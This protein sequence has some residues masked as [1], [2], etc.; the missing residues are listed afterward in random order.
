MV[1]EL[2]TINKENIE[3]LIYEIRGKQI[4]LDSDLARIYKCT[5]GT[6]DIN[7]AVNRNLNRFP[8]DFYFQLTKN[9]YEHL[10]FQIG[11]SKINGRGGIRKLPYVF[12]EQGVAMLS[13]ILKTDVAAE[14]SIN[15]MRTF[16]KMRNLIENNIYY[17]KDIGLIENRLIIHDN[18]IEDID[19]S[20]KLLQESFEKL[21]EKEMKEFLFFAGEVFNSYSKIIDIFNMSKNEIIIIDSY[22]DIKLLDIIKDIN[23]KVIIITRKNNLLRELDINKYNKQYSNLEVIYDNSFH[24][25]YI[26]LDKK[27]F[28]SVGTSFNY[29]GN[30]TF[31][32]NKIDEIEYKKLLL[33]K[34]NSIKKEKILS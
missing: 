6:K 27:I 22:A 5:N 31:G 19:N 33:S 34:I 32:I 26:I 17:F 7:K 24:D 13:S 15:I 18:K 25:R 28:Y 11:T 2:G 21:E 4:M 3:D 16:V 10:K 20:I 23:R 30:K 14:I 8:K 9:E 12:T 29:L 1:N